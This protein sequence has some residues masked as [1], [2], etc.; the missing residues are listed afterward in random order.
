MFA[1][2]MQ[3]TRLVALAFVAALPLLS[4]AEAHAAPGL[5]AAVRATA[6]Q[7]RSTPP[8]QV[9]VRSKRDG[10]ISAVAGRVEKNDLDKVVVNVGGK[11]NNYDSALVAR[12]SWGDVPQ[13][14]RDGVS[15]MDRRSFSDAV[16]Q[17]RIAAAD[18]SARAS[19]KA[20]AQLQTVDAL[21]QWGA[22]DPTRFV[23]AVTE[24]QSFLT[25][26]PANRE[27]P[28]ARRL[29]G[30]AQWLSGKPAEAA[31]TFK[32]LW[33]EL[34]GSTPTQGYDVRDC[35]EAGIQAARAFLEAKDTLGA[36]EVFAALESQAGP[37]AAGAADEDPLKLVFQSITDEATLGSGFVDIV[38]GQPKQALTFFQ[39]KV[40]SLS[41][42]SS[43]ALRFGSMAGL[44][45]ALLADGKPREA[46]V[47]LARAAA[48]DPQDRDRSARAQIKLAECFTKLD[49]TDART[50][51]CA[52]VRSVLADAG[53]TPAALRARQLQKELGC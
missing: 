29:L 22:E 24:A 39:S 14:Y 1:P 8:D 6:A 23:E 32:A 40:G 28:R 26:H 31:A 17:F 43:P 10:S 41:A 51:A 49:D 25:N 15:Y 16:A 47:Q 5:N 12:I 18:A 3:T 38:A 30:R 46:S 21:L 48:L 2:R 37:L 50:Q 7:E 35:L 20:S 27:T 52:R 42:T 44:G 34:Q 45:E 11:E 36:R 33:A 13:S 9:Y 19:V 53:S 4:A